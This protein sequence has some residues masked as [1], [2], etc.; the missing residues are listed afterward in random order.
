MDSAFHSYRETDEYDR[1]SKLSSEME[2]KRLKFSAESINEDSVPILAHLKD[3]IDGVVKMDNE[4]YQG[5][6]AG[7]KTKFV[8]RGNNSFGAKVMQ[9]TWYLIDKDFSQILRQFSIE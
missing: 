6:F 2:M 7:Y 9:Q 1:L 5:D 4:S 3:S 8:Y